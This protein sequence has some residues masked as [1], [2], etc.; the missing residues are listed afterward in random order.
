VNSLHGQG[1]NQVAD[2]LVV[3]AVSE[4]G[5]VEGISMPDA[6][7]FVIGVQWHAEFR[8]EAHSFNRALFETFGAAARRRAAAR[9][10][11]DVA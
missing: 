6:P 4:D 11:A 7:G 8:T 9:L 5:V 3:E 10:G 1:L 2:G